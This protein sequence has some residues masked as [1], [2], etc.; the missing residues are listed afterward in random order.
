MTLCVFNFD[1]KPNIGVGKYPADNCPE[2][3]KAKYFAVGSLGPV[4]LYA[5]D[6]DIYRYD[7]NGTNTGENFT[8]WP[9]LMKK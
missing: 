5:T 2:L 8:L 3:E 9:K 4:F 6:R 1:T 7:Y